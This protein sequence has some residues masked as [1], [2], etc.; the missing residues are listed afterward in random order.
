MSLNYHL[1][2]ANNKQKSQPN[3][4]EQI[5]EINKKQCR[6]Y[7]SQISY[8]NTDRAVMINFKK[9]NST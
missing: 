2:N 5:N 6:A 3:Q 1:E 9:Q 8:S 7:S 4:R